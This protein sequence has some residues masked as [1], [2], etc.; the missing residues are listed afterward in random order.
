MPHHMSLPP[1]CN[2]FAVRSEDPDFLFAMERK[3]RTRGFASTWRPSNNWL[4]AFAPLPG[5]QLDGE[6]VRD[7]GLAFAE[8]RDEVTGI[9]TTPSP[10]T[11]SK[12]SR[13]A[14]DQP[15]SLF[16]LA[17]N[18][19]FLRFRRDGGVTLVRS[20]SGRVPFYW[21][22]KSGRLVLATRLHFFPQLLP[23]SFTLD[24]F[25]N[26][27]WTNGHCLFPDGRT[28]LTDV[29]CVERGGYASFGSTATTPRTGTYWPQMSSGWPN[30]ALADRHARLRE[31]LTNAVRRDLHPEGG[32]LL[33]LS[34]GLDS[35]CLAVVASRLAK[36][37]IATW[38]HLP[39]RGLN[40]ET[41]KTFISPLAELCGFERSWEVSVDLEK[42]AE[43]L[44]MAPPIVFQVLHPALCDLPRVNSE[45]PVRVLIG[46]EFADE[47][48]GSFCTVPDWMRKASIAQLAQSVARGDS[49]A[50]DVA[51]WLKHRWL[52]LTGHPLV[53]LPLELPSLIRPELRAEYAEWR[54][55]EQ[56][57][58]AGDPGDWRYLRLR[59]RHEE[60]PAMNWEACSALGIRRSVP[61]MDRD[62]VELAFGC[63]PFDL[64]RPGN[65]KLLKAAMEGHV[66]PPILHQPH[67][68]D[69]GLKSRAESLQLPWQI[70]LPM[71]LAPIIRPDWL[72]KPPKIVS[73]REKSSLTQLVTID[74]YLLAV[75]KHC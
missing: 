22:S 20:C 5:G 51:R 14:D 69:W 11:F 10:E 9:Q 26:A 35:C 31:L 32:N 29:R 50:R 46:G 65:K 74:K 15:A 54:D 42:R 68:R 45:W 48:C 13:L 62:V 47:V 2:L 36:R 17:G 40:Y 60:F 38:S 28:F 12:I 3:L 64:I 58:A 44:E 1:Q 7:A 73:Y 55:R 63:H 23:D 24:P 72:P 75:G 66:P 59:L 43:R 52:N 53:P 6:D 41:E 30:G 49:S 37:R 33:T 34:G 4:V 56:R 8:G 21:S 70:Q 71:T 16:Q 57:R 27:V 18:F 67:K 39:E 25:T 19:G 61:F